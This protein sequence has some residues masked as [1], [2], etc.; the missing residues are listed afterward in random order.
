M[1]PRRVLSAGNGLTAAN[2][3]SPQAVAACLR[4]RGQL[5]ARRRGDDDLNPGLLD[6]LAA[7]RD[8]AVLVPLICRPVGLHVLLTRRT[9]HLT[10]HAGQ[11]AFPGG[12]VDP[13]DR[14]CV[15]TALREARE[16]VALD[17]AAVEVAGFLDPY[18]TRSGYRVR[19]VVGLVRPDAHVRANPDEVAEIFEVPLA[20][21]TEPG[22]RRTMA[23]PEAGAQRRYHEFPYG[24]HRI[25]GATAGMLVNLAE[26]LAA[27]DPGA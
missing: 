12:R 25:W 19:P 6:G 1:E 27:A 5:S 9:G 16:E 7:A 14:D 17:P 3:I 13:D 4:A 21:F 11:I 23:H 15:T 8:A 10:A 20:V 22:T 24:P 18:I 26:I 2:G